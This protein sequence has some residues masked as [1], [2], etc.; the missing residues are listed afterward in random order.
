VRLKE[1]EERMRLLM[2]TQKTLGDAIEGLEKHR[3]SLRDQET[4]LRA[5]HLAPV[6]CASARAADEQR[7]VA[8][9]EVARDAAGPRK[10]PA[11]AR[12]RS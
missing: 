9:E 4:T 8:A 1:Y 11:A 10:A 12:A 5:E 7:R 3:N 6:R 2:Q